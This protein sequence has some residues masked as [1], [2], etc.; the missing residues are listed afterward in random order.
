MSTIMHICVY[1]LTYFEFYMSALCLQRSERILNPLAA[2]INRGECWEPNPGPPEEQPAFL[3]SE[4]SL[5]PCATSWCDR[6]E[7]VKADDPETVQIP[8]LGRVD[9]PW[10]AQNERFLFICVHSAECA[11]AEEWVVRESFLKS[12]TTALRRQSL[13]TACSD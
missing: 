10:V 13:C 5:Q 3:T 8:V 7:Q 1:L 4:P 11:S 12:V 6:S 2:V 9:K